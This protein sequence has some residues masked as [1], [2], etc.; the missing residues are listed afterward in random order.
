MQMHENNYK[1]YSLI[2]STVDNT[3]CTPHLGNFIQ[4]FFPFN[5]ALLLVTWG[6]YSFY[7]EVNTYLL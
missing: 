7:F 2:S 3:A 5:E 4:Y 1:E 6:G